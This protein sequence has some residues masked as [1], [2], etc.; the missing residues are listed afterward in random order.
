M[1]EMLRVTM[2]YLS[3]VLI[4]TALSMFLPGQVRV[5][6]APV[7]LSK[8]TQ[9]EILTQNLVL[10]P[11]VD[12]QMKQ[13]QRFSVSPASEWQGRTTE[14]DCVSQMVWGESR[15]Q[16]Y[17]GMVATAASAINRSKSGLY[18]HNLCSVVRSPGQYHGYWGAPKPVRNDQWQPIY[19]AVVAASYHRDK[20]PVAYRQVLHFST[21]Q[22]E[23]HNNKKIV[24]TIG[25]HVY[26]K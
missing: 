9:P 21:G 8:L 7:T 3:T 2:T 23:F 4:V 20:L 17:A 15:N 22:S 11:K 18:G 16:S 14:L 26:V 19:E 5:K 10:L 1:Y 25:D 24:M 6:S 12:G 13:P